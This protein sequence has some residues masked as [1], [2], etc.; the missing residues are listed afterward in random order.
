M[1]ETTYIHG[2]DPEEQERLAGLNAL[3]NPP[4]LRF[5]SLKETDSVLEVGSGLGLLAAEVA[6]RVPQGEVVGL[7]F[8]PDQLAQTPRTVPH[9]HFIRGDAH[10]LPFPDNHFDVVYC[11]YVL[12]HVRNPQQVLGE[13]RRVL[14]P[15]GRAYAQENDMRVVIFDPDCPAT[16]GIIEKIIAMQTRMGGDARMGK[17]LFGLFRRA[18]F[19]DIE[20]S[21]APEIYP[22]SSPHFPLWIENAV[23]L[24][25][26]IADHLQE[27]GLATREEIEAGYREMNALLLRD[28]ACALFHWNR[29]CGVK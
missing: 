8:S 1:E 29:A 23:R 7:E 10:T 19:R 27:Y 15:G 6:Q 22:A 2:T 18:G 4:F 14:K 28:D 26:G 13:M 5:L 12:E 20:L 11:R 25:E 3:T 16:E 9:L 24:L 17:R 21:F